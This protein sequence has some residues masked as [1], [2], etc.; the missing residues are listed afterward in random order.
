MPIE[1][2]SRRALNRALL[3]RQFLLEREPTPPLRAI[4]RLVGM[5][6]QQARPP[7][8]GLWARLQNF[9]REELTR[10]LL[11]RKVVRV[12]AMRCTLHLMSTRD[13]VALRPALQPALSATVR[14]AV[15]AQL[16]GVDLP[17]L[18]ACARAHFEGAHCTFESLRDHL[19]SSGLRGDVRALAYTVR[20]HLPLVQVPTDTAWGFL[21]R[22]NFATA[23]SWLGE[24]IEIA[25]EAPP[26]DAL[27]LR[28]LAAF[29]PASAGDAQNWSGLR[30]LGDAFA[31]LRPKLR[32]FRDE[33]GRE[34]LDLPKAPRPD[35]DAPAPVRF[36][37]DYDNLILGHADRTRV[38]A[39]A[40]RRAVVTP[41]LRVLATFLVD[42]FVAGTWKVERKAKGAKHVMQP[43]APLAKKV[44]DGLVG[45][46]EALARF[47][48]PDVVK[49]ESVF[50]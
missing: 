34:L 45:E 35:E 10:L 41:N 29:G 39:D 5:Q 48:E 15:T 19:E 46:G 21:A 32:A 50:K 18:L 30:G 9:K 24:P 8:V 40:H 20:T 37:P 13:Y 3:A 47:V 17:A 49:V 43:V 25:G 7:Y 33:A 6:A 27:V 26:A 28:Y 36:L 31:R 11:A 23:E 2:L 38:I 4:E 22:A 14:S 16:G 42:G 44:R 12:T 1:M